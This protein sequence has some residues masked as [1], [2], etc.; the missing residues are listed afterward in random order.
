MAAIALQQGEGKQSSTNT[1]AAV[2]DLRRTLMG[3]SAASVRYLKQL[4]EMEIIFPG[5]S[6]IEFG[7]QEVQGEAQD[8]QSAVADVA[9]ALGVTATIPVFDPPVYMGKIFELLGI[10]HK[11]IDVN[12]L[13]GSDFFD[14]NTQLVPPSVRGKYDWVNNEGTTEHVCNQLNAFRAAHEYCKPGGYISH[15][16][17]IM[18][19]VDHGLINCTPK[20]WMILIGENL[21]RVVEKRFELVEGNRRLPDWYSDWSGTDFCYSDVWAHL[22][23]QKVV[24]APFVI[25]LDHLET[26]ADGR[27]AARLKRNASATYCVGPPDQVMSTWKNSIKGRLRRLLVKFIG[28]YT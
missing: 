26:D 6:V 24:E 17:P 8:I 19:W 16:V 13:Y 7:A 2:T 15:S 4:I 18:G 25:P 14:L 11:A 28:R 9:S 5:C 22:I 3:Y 20:F 10:H 12:L 1:V 23:L 21:Y 27:I